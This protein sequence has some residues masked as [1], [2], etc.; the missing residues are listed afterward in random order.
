MSTKKIQLVTSAVAIDNTLTQSG[1]AA[2]AKAVGDL[3]RA[4]P[5]DN[6]FAWLLAATGLAVG[7]A[8]ATGAVL[9]DETGAIL[10]L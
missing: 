2:D 10:I 6:D 5:D 3:W 1:V 4:Y 7:I 9:T 8:D